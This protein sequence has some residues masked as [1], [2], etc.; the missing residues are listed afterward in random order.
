MSRF[1]DAKDYVFIKHL[2]GKN[3]L[4]LLEKFMKEKNIDEEK[5]RHIENVAYETQHKA[6]TGKVLRVDFDHLRVNKL[7]NV[8]IP[9][10]ILEFYKKVAS[11]PFEVGGFL[12][13]DDG[14]KVDGEDIRTR[15][16]VYFGEDSMVDFPNLDY[17]IE[18]HTHPDEPPGIYN[19]P[20]GD[21]IIGILRA[22]VTLGTQLSL[23]ITKDYLYVMH[24]SALLLNIYSDLKKKPRDQRKLENSIRFSTDRA[25]E[26][27]LRT[28]NRDHFE[29]AMYRA[30][31]NFIEY[32]FTGRGDELEVL[33]KNESGK[34]TKVSTRKGLLAPIQVVTID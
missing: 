30:G 31:F 26:K 33:K 15:L 19:P 28:G 1:L 23:V 8:Y 34:W 22:S 9:L 2:R 20:S 14:S 7:A 17:E 27:A 13:F 11:L 32:K 6:R 12:D 4:H 18:W 24:P 3:K 21:D 25:Y 29:E 16:L 5:F 10:D